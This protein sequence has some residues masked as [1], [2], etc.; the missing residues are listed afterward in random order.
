[1]FKQ[2][3]KHIPYYLGNCDV[4]IDFKK[5]QALESAFIKA[6]ENNI[7]SEDIMQYF[8][9]LLGEHYED[10]E[11]RKM[12]KFVQIKINNV[13]IM[14]EIQLRSENATNAN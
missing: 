6:S 10:W 5:F 12:A 13:R 11:T 14:N 9:D 2:I 3:I 7:L 1:M 8:K 4:L